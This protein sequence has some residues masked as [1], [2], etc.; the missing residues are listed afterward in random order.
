MVAKRVNFVN[1]ECKN[2]SFVQ[3]MPVQT[4]AEPDTFFKLGKFLNKRTLWGTFNYCYCNQV[5]GVHLR[6]IFIIWPCVIAELA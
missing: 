5:Y 4:Y 1:P 2:N 3:G 6:G